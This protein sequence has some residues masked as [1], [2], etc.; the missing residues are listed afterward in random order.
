MALEWNCWGRT[1]RKKEGKGPLKKIGASR[2]AETQEEL[3]AQPTQPAHFDSPPPAAN[4]EESSASAE[5]QNGE[6]AATFRCSQFLD[7]V[8]AAA[9]AAATKPE[10]SP[11]GYRKVAR[12][13]LAVLEVL[14][15]HPGAALSVW[16]YLAAQTLECTLKAY[17]TKLGLPAPVRRKGHDLI[18]LW[19]TAAEASAAAPIKLS[20]AVRPPEW[21]VMLNVFHDYPFLDRYPGVYGLAVKTK[22][23][24]LVKVLGRILA[25]VD[26][27]FQ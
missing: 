6:G 25:Q 5:R 9:W 17:V 20:I 10:A 18:N 7:L 2:Q 27:A 14:A 3:R 19:R 8:E 26:A 24:Q 23:T 12:E 1:R 15:E 22:R 4:S 16:V 13:F 11:Q 21:C